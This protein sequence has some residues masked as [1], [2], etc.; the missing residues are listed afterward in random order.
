MA[1]YSVFW[2][3]E[4]YQHKTPAYPLKTNSKIKKIYKNPTFIQK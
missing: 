2:I 1:L 4:N 3:W